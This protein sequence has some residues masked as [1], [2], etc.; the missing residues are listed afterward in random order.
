M[1]AAPEKPAASARRQP[2]V[3][4]KRWQCVGRTSRS[5]Q[6]KAAIRRAQ[7][8]DKPI[9]ASGRALA[10]RHRPDASPYTILVVDDDVEVLS[11][12]A[13]VL[14][15]TMCRVITS[16]TGAAALETLYR[17]PSIDLMLVDVVMPVL[18]GLQLAAQAR[19]AFPKLRVVFTSGYYAELPALSQRLID[20]GQFIAKPWRASELRSLISR[21]MAS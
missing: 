8:A 21:A 7:A 5:E 15:E 19:L 12:A 3:T 13:R 17:E 2:G 6:V 16:S 1:R 20:A 10:R 4:A 14:T 11:I 18:G 9:G